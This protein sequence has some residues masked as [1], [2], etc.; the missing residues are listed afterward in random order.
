MALGY[1]L[2]SGRED[3]ILAASI[4]DNL[5]RKIDSIQL[6]KEVT[7][8]VPKMQTKNIKYSF[9]FSYLNR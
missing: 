9:F 6:N 4:A 3:V 7:R 5:A 2:T 1:F 8:H